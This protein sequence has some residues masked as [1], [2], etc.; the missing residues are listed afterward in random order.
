M[1]KQLKNFLYTL[2]LLGSERLELAIRT[3]VGF[4]LALI[5][6]SIIKFLSL[7]T[8]L[9][10]FRFIPSSIAVLFASTTIRFSNDQ[11]RFNAWSNRFISKKQYIKVGVLLKAKFAAVHESMHSAIKYIEN[12]N[13]QNPIMENY[14]TSWMYFNA[15]QDKF[16]QFISKQKKIRE[17]LDLL[18]K[19][20]SDVIRYL[21][22][23]TRHMGHL[24]LLFLYANYYK[25]VDPNRVIAIWPNRSPNKFYLKQLLK[26]FPLKVKL[27]QESDTWPKDSISLIDTM[28]MSRIKNSAWRFEPLG[29]N[30]SGQEFPEYDIDEI[31]RLKPDLDISDN[32]METLKTIGFDPNRW[33]VVLHVKESKLGNQIYGESRDADINDYQ[34]G[35]NLVRDFGGQVVRM[36]SPSFP[37]LM[38]GF[39]AIDYA[40]SNIRLDYIDYWL[41]ANCKFW[42]GNGN[43][44]SGAVLPFGKRRIYSNQWPIDANGQNSDLVL[45]KLLYDT[46][47]KKFLTFEETSRNILGRVQDRNLLKNAGLILMQ[48]SQ[49]LIQESMLEMIESQYLIRPKTIQEKEFYSATNTPENTP[50]MRFPKTF[51]E[52]YLHKITS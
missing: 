29:G 42:V 16:S 48:N 52:F 21:P 38:N 46:Q 24:G 33:F 49:Q 25:N 39:P 37:K 10:F 43:G 40:H 51:G 47:L 36:G 22:E 27:M 15:N 19:S 26:N 44:A 34:L 14:V 50:K 35:C 18:S 12:L 5:T 28:M 17:E 31:S 7:K 30:G 8:P 9:D 1:L 13:I 20:D 2:S 45:P 3:R 11:K 4:R 32:A 41:W 6:T 23:H